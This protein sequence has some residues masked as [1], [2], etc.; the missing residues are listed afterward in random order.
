MPSFGMSPRRNPSRSGMAWRSVCRFGGLQ[1]AEIRIDGPP[2][3]CLKTEWAVQLLRHSQVQNSLSQTCTDRAIT[4]QESR[5]KVIRPTLRPDIDCR[6]SK[7]A[8]HLDFQR[9]AFDRMPVAASINRYEF[10]PRFFGRGDA[11]DSIE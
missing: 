6:Q 2:G 3:K 1:P 4:L 5:R 9:I 8:A 7:K 11:S 10:L